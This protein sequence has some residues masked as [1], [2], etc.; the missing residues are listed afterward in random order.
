MDKTLNNG[1]KFLYV[2][3]I[4]VLDMPLHAMLNRYAILA[5]ASTSS[6]HHER[7][8]DIW[9]PRTMQIK[10]RR[11]KRRKKTRKNILTA[12][13]PCLPSITTIPM[14]HSR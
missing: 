9:S 2:R 10:R 14:K 1:C 4:P 13:H 6:L 7:D 12:S 11:K 5:E 3:G 8:T